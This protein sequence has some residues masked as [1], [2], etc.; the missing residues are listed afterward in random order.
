MELEGLLAN[1]SQLGEAAKAAMTYLTSRVHSHSASLKVQTSKGNYPTSLTF[2]K[3][4][5]D[6]P[7]SYHSADACQPWDTSIARMLLS[8]VAC[9]PEAVQ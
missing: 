2:R 9:E 6:V 3:E 1:I 4:Q 7:S 8:A 5:V